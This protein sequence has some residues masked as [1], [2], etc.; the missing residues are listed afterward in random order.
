MAAGSS[1]GDATGRMAQRPLLELAE[2]VAAGSSLPEILAGVV[3]TAAALVPQT[4]VQ[5]WL[6]SEDGAEPRL[7]AVHDAGRAGAPDP[8]ASAAPTATFARAVMD[9]AEP[10]R[11][12][13]PIDGEKTVDPAWTRA[14]A[15][16][17]A[18]GLRLVRGSRL[19]GALCIFTW[20][21]YPFTP[22]KVDLLRS[23]AAYAAVAIEGATLLEVAASRLRRLDVLREIERE[24]S[25]QRDPEA[26]MGVI[27][28]RATE[29]LA[30]DTGAVYLV[31]PATGILRPQAAY[32]RADWMLDVRIALG[33]GMVGVTA[34]TRQGL[35]VNDYPGSPLALEA[36]R[37]LHRSA[38]TQ[39][40]MAGD[41]L[42]G[43]IL[44]TRDRSPRPFTADDLA[45][46][47]DFA[48]QASI[49]LANARLLRLASARAERVEAAGQVG[50]LLAATRDSDRILDLI[51]EKCRDVLDAG[52][53]GFF[54]LEG[55]RLRYVRGFGLDQALSG[56]RTIAVGEGAVGKAAA[57][58]RTVET[59]D[60]LADPRLR[61]SPEFRAGVA[62][63][64]SRAV[65]AVPLLASERV[66]G[67]IAI[68]HPVGVRV[69]A[70]DRAF[71]E[72]L[73]AHAAVALDNAALFAEIRRR[74]ETAEALAGITQ[75]LTA[76]LDLRTVITRVAEAV[77]RLLGA[78]G[79]AIGLVGP[80]GAVRLTART[81]LGAE[82]L[83]R[84]VVKAG[85]GI[86]G[87]VFQHRE[88]FRTTDYTVDPRVP[89]TFAHEVG[90]AGIRAVLAVPIRLQGEVV[91]VLYAFWDRT[92]EIADE[93]V[94]LATDM[95]RVVAVTVAN[96]RLYE[97]ARTREAEARALFDV[98]R[99]IA[100][101]LD[102]ERVFDRIV[103]RVLGLMRV[104]ACG[105]F[106]LDPDGCLRYVRG[107]GLSAE[108]VRD[109]AVR[110]GDGTTGRCVVD[111]RAVWARDLLAEPGLVADATVRGLVER[112]G[113]RGVLSVPILTQDAP[114]GALATY[115]WEPHDPTPGEVQTLTSLAT[116]AAV[117]IE[118]ARLYDE[119]R[120][121]VGRLERLTR[122]NRAVSAS[123][124][125]DDVLGEIARAAGTFFD[126]PLVTLWLADEET[127]ALVR[128]AGHGAPAVLA[129]VPERV[130]YGEGEV[131]L[132]AE[133]RSAV[134]D[135]VLDAS[136]RA[137][138]RPGE[139]DART[140][141][142]IPI[143]LDDRLLGVLA[144]NGGRLAGTADPA[145]LEALVAQAAV[146]I[147][148]ARLYEEARG[149]ELEARRALEEL[150]RTQ[151]QLVRMEKLRAL[152]EM[153]S[154]VAHDFNNV[155]AVILGRVQL[156]QR[157]VQ[158]A[159][160]SRWLGIVEQAALD[161]AQTVRRIQEF[162][163]IRRDAP[164]EIIDLNEVVREA[165]EMT[166]TRWQDEA[167]SRGV[168]IRVAL[169]LSRVPAVDGQPSE[170]REALT[171]LLLNAVDALPRG[172]EI[173][174]ATRVAQGQVE[175]SV[176]D[177]GIGMS[178]SVRRRIFEPF[179]STKGPSGTGLGL[180]MV[181]GIIS[182]HGGEID[183]QSAEGVG[184]TFTI[185]LPLGRAGR[186]VGS[187][188]EVGGTGAVRVLVIDDEPHVRDTLE[189]ILRQQRHEVVVADD[190]PSGLALFQR[191]RFDVVMTD[192]AM[193]GMSGWQVAQAIK[194]A[195][196]GTPV[197]LVTGWGVELPAE[198]LRVHGVD[199]VMSK[200][201]RFEDVRDVVASFRDAAPLAG[202]E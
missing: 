102:P 200:P 130:A 69:P 63:F 59:A 137:G 147:Q 172:G 156:M 3:R 108:F 139:S 116:M 112:E 68:Y 176:S 84:L 109:M 51:A 87:W 140:F 96:A 42:Q 194:L 10:V 142:G 19:I 12:V 120:R 124:R 202:P 79:G 40:L 98:G 188:A 97:E 9:A 158:D 159:T 160:L 46:L 178:E 99:L 189:E 71:L 1:P 125:L 129:S 41:T 81:G 162:T 173:R 92:L 187:V 186:G 128:R 60:T 56:I 190:G 49:A 127:R 131:G 72:S 105:L 113:Y 118:N 55:D 166:R 141:S 100:A 91:G 17:S 164:T 154:G 111:R 67:V 4:I 62:A 201:F 195:R 24:I 163:R 157:K 30:G 138:D 134:V 191:E 182:R 64:G 145:L 52:A 93:H 70:E 183:V 82:G 36:F 34:S 28:R 136:G 192:L 85:Q 103:D 150:R 6:V 199:R 117:A 170:L 152:G 177:T 181:Y 5:V 89:S 114:L 33:E 148:N 32:N 153:A 57:D 133:R 155:L 83:R 146:A 110:S 143:M 95:A 75:T 101:T 22:A 65:V 184:S 197:V 66:L 174:V 185:R 44:V 31:D 13:A 26:L 180:A 29:L 80:D 179:F 149:H 196:P 25:D 23:L 74:Q 43:V 58:R 7:A 47:G 94:A 35:I 48:V 193:P 37:G 144:I 135:A 8:A 167:Q 198:Q 73:A 119:T 126:A 171:N 86:T 2:A 39:P 169:D 21:P 88:P 61:F 115:W 20:R 11:V 50:Q 15:I 132:I 38:V 106:R 78:D 107:A 122:L 45:Q 168:S 77:Q 151:E 161:G 76:S 123:L 18:A 54:R 175:L 14:R 53:F 90:R 121:Y 104:R 165:V 27:S 16:R